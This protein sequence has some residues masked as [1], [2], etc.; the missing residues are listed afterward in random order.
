MGQTKWKLRTKHI[1]IDKG[2]QTFQSRNIVEQHRTE[3]KMHS[4]IKGST[5]KE[6]I[7]IQL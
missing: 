3:M 7:N 1:D 6:Q 5:K 4:Y 2:S